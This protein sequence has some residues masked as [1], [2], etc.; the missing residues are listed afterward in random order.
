MTKIEFQWVSLIYSYFSIAMH[1][2][3]YIGTIEQQSIAHSKICTHKV[4][5]GYR[6]VVSFFFVATDG[7][8]V[9]FHVGIFVDVICGETQCNCSLKP[10]DFFFQLCLQH[11][12]NVQIAPI[13]IMH[14]SATCIQL[15]RTSRCSI[16]V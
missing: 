7:C 4:E 15:F 8:C 14:W 5:S 1:F 12:S 13:N 10:L 2:F 6:P 16:V 9:I 3:Q 11:N